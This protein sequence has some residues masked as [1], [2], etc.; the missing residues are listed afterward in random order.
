MA[1]PDRHCITAQRT[2]ASAPRAPAAASAPYARIVALLTCALVALVASCSGSSAGPKSEGV[3]SVVALATSAVGAFD[4][5]AYDVD[6]IVGPE[7][8]STISSTC[9]VVRWAGYD[10]WP[11]SFGDNRS[12]MAIHAYDAQGNLVNVKELVGARYPWR[13]DVDEA[14]QTVTFHGQSDHTVTMTFDELRQLR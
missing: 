8:P 4:Q 6:C 3:P 7:S 13:I 2:H 11:L 12:S 1:I 10:Y 9:P 14:A 5:N